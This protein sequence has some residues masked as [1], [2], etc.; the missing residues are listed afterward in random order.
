MQTPSCRS[1]DIIN[2]EELLQRVGGDKQLLAELV[3]VF[4]D[5]YPSVLKEMRSSID[6]GNLESLRV[7]A[8][9]LKG[10]A[11]YLA[12]ESVFTMACNLENLSL[13]GE[14]PSCMSVVAGLAAE[15]EKVREALLVIVKEP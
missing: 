3:D 14:L 7:A 4:V 12:A 5:D 15:L 8:H 2:T 11:A 10:T 1:A 9:T 13:K 6:E